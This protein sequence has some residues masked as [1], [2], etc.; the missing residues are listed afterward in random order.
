VSL[1]LVDLRVFLRPSTAVAVGVVVPLAECGGSAGAG[2]SQP[3]SP[4]AAT[5]PASGSPVPATPVVTGTP[6]ARP[7]VIP[8]YDDSYGGLQQLASWRLLPG[9]NGL[10]LFVA[11]QHAGLKQRVRLESA[12]GVLTID[13]SDI[14]PLPTALKPANGEG[15][16]VRAGLFFP[17]DDALVVLRLLLADRTARPQATVRQTQLSTT[18]LRVTVTLQ[19]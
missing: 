8:R 17:P 15:P 10:E 12:P 11:L 2:T 13:L 6:T 16:I 9:A 4:S 14:V 18:A 7:T 3:T 1:N 19:E 5:T